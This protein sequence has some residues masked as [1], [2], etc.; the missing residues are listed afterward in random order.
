M[1]VDPEVIAALEAAVASDPGNHA[2]RLHLAGLLHDAERDSDALAHAAAVLQQ[3]P[4]N[5][6]AL[7]V[8]AATAD[9][10]GEHG[11]ADGYRHLAAALA[12]WPPSAAPPPQPVPTG[13][14]QMPDTADE[15]FQRWRDSPPLPE[16][17]IGELSRP[18]M[19]LADVGGMDEVKRRLDLSFLGPLRSP[20]LRAQFGKPLRGGLLLWGPPGCGKTYLARAL[21]G[22]L[23]AS[24]YEVGLS[25]VLDMW[26]GSSERNLSTIFATA[27]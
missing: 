25:D 18:A 8:A 23:S 11:R 12:G 3:Q 27:R 6:A 1:A 26:V 20:E 17:E 5:I 15:L 13:P 19:T 14:D 10:V 24:F 9:A 16:P 4:D 2:L 7:G 21:A 22:E